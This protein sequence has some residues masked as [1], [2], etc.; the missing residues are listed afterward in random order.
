MGG[1]A[2]RVHKTRATP[3][4]SSDGAT[5]LS[6]ALPTM[7]CEMPIA[8]R[9][10]TTTPNQ[11]RATDRAV[12]LF[13]DQDRTLRRLFGPNV[14][15][16]F[17][18][19]DQLRRAAVGPMVDRRAVADARQLSSACG[20]S[21]AAAQLAEQTRSWQKLGAG[22]QFVPPGMAKVALDAQRVPAAY[23][24][25]GVGSRLAEDVRARR[26][27]I[28]DDTAANVAKLSR[29]AAA[30]AHA[31]IARG[32]S[33]ALLD[34]VVQTRARHRV[35]NDQ[36]SAM[37]ATTSIK[38]S[39]QA[40][41]A[42][43]SIATAFDARASVAAALIGGSVTRGIAEQMRG[44]G[45]LLGEHNSALLAATSIRRSLLAT[46]LATSSIATAF[47]FRAS[48]LPALFDGLATLR[49]RD[50]LATD[51]T[52]TWEEIYGVALRELRAELSGQPSLGRGLQFHLAL[53]VLEAM[54]TTAPALPA[55]TREEIHEGFLLAHAV[56]LSVRSYRRTLR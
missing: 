6:R 41:A 18:L 9:D 35:I 37:L 5:A 33:A 55:T 34:I 31:S 40:T 51:D 28:A 38:R 47:N 42:I 15:D 26:K 48:A 36:N 20:T 21:G 27:L 32:T 12:K 13:A 22:P 14:G 50:W 30:S 17:R 10:P 24:A 8:A 11:F 25:A 23:R 29:V 44:L 56:A 52:P 53:L 19:Q 7:S 54:L 1:G 16:Y 3:I 49:L 45:N 4:V 2:R 46:Q 39:L 43:P